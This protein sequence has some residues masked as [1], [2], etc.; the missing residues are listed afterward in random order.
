MFLSLL[1]YYLIDHSSFYSPTSKLLFDVFSQMLS[2]LLKMCFCVPKLTEKEAKFIDELLKAKDVD[3]VL[4]IA[5]VE[6]TF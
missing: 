6:K 3:D 4:V 1:Y 2:A 5:E